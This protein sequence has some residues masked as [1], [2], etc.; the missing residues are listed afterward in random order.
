MLK[1]T[2]SV[3][4]KILQNHDTFLRIMFMS[5]EAQLTDRLTKQCLDIFL[6]EFLLYIS[7]GYLQY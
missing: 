3:Y 6:W 7:A 2:E 4:T 1:R 5:F